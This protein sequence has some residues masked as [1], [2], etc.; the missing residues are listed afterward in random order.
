MDSTDD[1]AHTATDSSSD[2]RAA[3]RLVP[4][5]LEEAAGEEPQA[6]EVA[7]RAWEDGGRFLPET[8]QELADW[9]T[10][11]VTDTG[12]TGDE[13]PERPGPR[14]TVGEKEALHRWLRGQGHR[15]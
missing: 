4:L 3:A 14:V 1:S 7:R 9:A 2:A 5:W 10:A 6:A 8:A 12:F 11:R 13:G 15:V